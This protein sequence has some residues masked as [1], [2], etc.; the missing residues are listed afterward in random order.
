MRVVWTIQLAA[1]GVVIVVG[2]VVA[3]L[4]A[5]VDARLPLAALPLLAFAVW[6]WPRANYARWS[7]SLEA[8]TLELQSG[9]F[10]RSEVSVPYFRVQN[11]DISQGPVERRLGLAE[12]RMKTAAA[13]GAASLPGVPMSDAEE[14]RRTILERA[15]GDDAV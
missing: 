10:W 5:E 12:L 4:V 9:I 1:A 6:W 13:G 14:L 11:V 8:V 2:G 15:S 7:Y 3:A